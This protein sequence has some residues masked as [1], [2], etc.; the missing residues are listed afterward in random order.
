MAVTRKPVHEAG[1]PIRLEIDLETRQRILE[2]ARELFMSKGFKGVSMRD[3]AEIVKVTPAALYYHF[4]QGKEDLF[5]E[6]VKQMFEDYGR[7]A[8]KAVEPGHTTREK[9][10]LLAVHIISGLGNNSG[11]PMLMR[12]V[13]EYLDKARQPEIWKHY[14]TSYI[15]SIRD[16]FQEGIDQGE[17]SSNIPTDAL[18]SIF[19]GMALSFKW[20][21]GQ[22]C[23]EDP[24]E[25]GRIADIMVSVL[26]DGVALRKR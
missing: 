6:V 25:I 13:R 11:W 9:L 19:Y 8:R 24:V 15:H 20:G 7:A 12:D 2:A 14:G 17:L 26:M 16:I 23:F 22:D 10:R 21:Q 5:I 18:S 1:N 4:P 3:V